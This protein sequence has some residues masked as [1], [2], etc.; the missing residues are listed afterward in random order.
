MQLGR[1][2]VMDQG[3]IDHVA[4]ISKIQ[5]ADKKTKVD[6]EDEYKNATHKVEAT[7]NE[8][9][10]DNVKFGYNSNTNDFFVRIKKGDTEF[11]Y[12]TEDMMKLKQ[13]LME[14]YKNSHA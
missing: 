13:T 12:P 2:E 8:V 3:Q 1:L 10:L 11:Q 9:I 5:E 14:A 7:E 4:K 6:P